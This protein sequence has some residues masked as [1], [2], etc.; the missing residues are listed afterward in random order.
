MM[1]VVAKYDENGGDI[2]D[3]NK[4]AVVEM[5]KG[6]GAR[7]IEAAETLSLVTASVPAER[8][9]DV[10]GHDLVCRVGYDWALS[11]PTIGKMRVTVGATADDLRRPIGT[12]A[13]GSGVTVGIVDEG[14]N[15]PLGINDKVVGRISCDDLGCRY[16]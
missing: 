1:V 7:D 10:S 13:N 5:L 3:G 12:V 8:I 15:H 16:A 6:V 11:H 2:S 9:L 14:V 4:A